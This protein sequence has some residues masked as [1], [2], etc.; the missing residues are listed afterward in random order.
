[1]LDSVR[2]YWRGRRSYQT[3]LYTVGALL[4]LGGLFHIVVFLVRG[5]PWSGPLSW[6]KPIVFGISFG[7]TVATIGWIMGFLRMPRVIGWGLAVPLAAASVTEVLLITMQ[8]WRGV[9]SHFNIT[10]PFDGEVFQWMGNMVAVVAVVISIVTIW[11]FVALSAPPTIAWAIRMGLVL[12]V[13]GQGFGGAIIANGFTRLDQG[14]TT[15]FNVFGSEGAMKVP[16]AVSM[17]GIQVL[18]FLAWLTGFT[19]WPERIG[20][21][22]VLA[23]SAGYA[24]LVVVAALQTFSGLAP[25]DLDAPVTA[26]LS[27]SAAL[28]LG[29]FAVAVG[30]LGRPRRPSP[31]VAR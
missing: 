18:P 1:M 28:L 7:L 21:A 17:H 10:T 2:G 6:R 19:R 31:A 30:G 24:G 5:G 29:A 27:I 13:A 16:H 3:L 11:S 23:G 14:L 26:L 25:F 15:G 22:I 9:P 8:Q 12:L 4:V 20:S